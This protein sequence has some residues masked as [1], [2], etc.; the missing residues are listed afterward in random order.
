MNPLVW[1]DIEK[2]I[3]FL[4]LYAI[5]YLLDAFIEVTTSMKDK[6]FQSVQRLF[7]FPKAVPKFNNVTGKFFA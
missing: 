5:K 3:C 4:V 1:R 2:C 7:L 6:N